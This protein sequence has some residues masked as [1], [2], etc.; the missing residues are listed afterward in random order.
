MRVES[1]EP[2]RRVEATCAGWATPRTIHRRVVT[3][4][5]PDLVLTD[6]LEGRPRPARLTLPL[7]PGLEPEL[8]GSRARVALATGGVL[9]IELPAARWDREPLDYYPEFG[10]CVERAA[11]VGRTQGWDRL[12]WRF[13][14]LGRG[15]EAG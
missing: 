10:R 14:V 13:R 7:A 11:L 2:G 4:V 6:T 9:E 1:L 15:R 12:V 8:A 3:F 5:G